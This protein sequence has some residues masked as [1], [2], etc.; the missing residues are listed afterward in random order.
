MKPREDR[1]KVMVTAR[2]RAGTA[3]T[4]VCILNLSTRGIGAH[5]DCPPPVGTYLEVRRGPNVIVARVVWAR[6]QRFGARCQDSISV[7][8]LLSDQ[9]AATS[10]GTGERRASPRPIAVRL[11][12]SRQS[13]RT[14]EFAGFVIAAAS[15]AVAGLASVQ[16]ILAKPLAAAM[17]AIG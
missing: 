11:D 2:M 12:A 17:S 1:R 5:A 9:P 13:A 15:A 16:H 10:R 3:W 14:I 6:Q 7:E 8:T 4:D